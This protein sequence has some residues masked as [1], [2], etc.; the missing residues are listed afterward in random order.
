MRQAPMSFS[1]IAQRAMGNVV[2]DNCG[3]VKNRTPLGSAGGIDAGSIEHLLQPA[4]AQTKGA[5][6][7]TNNYLAVFTSNKPGA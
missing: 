7:A 1:L 4:K 6:M 5:R 2:H 3:N